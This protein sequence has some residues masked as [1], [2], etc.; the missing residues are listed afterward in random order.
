MM[1]SEGE[2]D[3]SSCGSDLRSLMAQAEGKEYR[4]LKSL[5]D[6][7]QY[8]DSFVI[9]EGDYG[10]Q[11]YL[12]CPVSMV[13]CSEDTLRQLLSEI[14]DLHWAD[15]DGAMI[16]YER[17]PVGNGIAGGM[18]GA[19]AS[20]ELWLHDELEKAGLRNAVTDVVEGREAHLKGN[21]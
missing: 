11:I 10:G 15:P 5:E 16:C 2:H 17:R 13:R 3:S 14:D 21:S 7:R 20:T 19:I 8:A 6:A 4:P 1:T 18:G 12:T 9:F